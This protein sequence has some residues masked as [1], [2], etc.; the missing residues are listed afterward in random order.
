MASK[1]TFDL[2]CDHLTKVITAPSIGRPKAHVDMRYIH[3]DFS[4]EVVVQAHAYSNPCP[5]SFVVWRAD[6]GMDALS[7]VMLRKQRI[8]CYP[9]RVRWTNKERWDFGWV[10]AK[11]EIIDFAADRLPWIW[12]NDML[13]KYDLPI[14]LPE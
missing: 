12:V 9:W 2:L 1:S 3:T 6:V 7:A 13:K 8:A 5:V 4:S 14:P 11:D 10:R